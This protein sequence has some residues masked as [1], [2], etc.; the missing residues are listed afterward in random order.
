MIVNLKLTKIPVPFKIFYYV[1]L[2]LLLIPLAIILLI[3]KFIFNTSF[4]IIKD[5]F[6]G[7]LTANT[8]FFLRKIKMGRIKKKRYIGIATKKPSNTQLLKMYKETI[9]KKI[10]IIQ[11][12]NFLYFLYSSTLF[13]SLAFKY[14]ILN[15]LGLFQ[16]LVSE[17]GAYN[18]MQGFNDFYEF[19]NSTP[20][21][22]FTKKEEER[23]KNLLKKMGV[24]GWFICFHCRDYSYHGKNKDIG[25]NFRNC[26]INNYL[27]ATD[28]IIETGGFS[29]RMGAK[30]LNELPRS[31]N[32][33]MIDYA[34][35]CRTDFGD[36]YL[37]AKC[38]FFLC[39]TSGVFFVSIIFNV[40][41]AEANLIPLKY[42]PPRKEDL[43]IPKKI[44]SLKEK[45]FLT[46]EEIIGSD[47]FFYE[48]TELYIKA[49]LKVIEN[50]PE[51]ILDLAIE[52]NERL[53]GRWKSTTEG[54]LLQQKFKDLFKKHNRFYGFPSRIGTTFLIKN[55][56]LLK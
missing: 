39:N 23:G 50:T 32:I 28:Y 12:P 9:P 26:A 51:E 36:I 8:E 41:V 18:R 55:R 45:R 7:H 43:F 15:K 44:W 35:N 37:P 22:K 19:N 42:V 48:D 38:K 4:V 47:I 53:D 34:T 54:E 2:N 27:K 30:V 14:S 49:G 3:L 29:I 56:N 5:E 52:M 10:T 31:E 20:S 17:K 40:P 6:I 33:K 21:L 11:V 46:F 16:D 1:L 24:D 13:K 25:Q